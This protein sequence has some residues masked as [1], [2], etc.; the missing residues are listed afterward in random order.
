MKFFGVTVKV[1]SQVK[2]ANFL[3]RFQCLKLKCKWQN[4]SEVDLRLSLTKLAHTGL[5]CLA[6]HRNW[7]SCNI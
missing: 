2:Q 1:V 7:K 5:D 3:L 6:F 4:S